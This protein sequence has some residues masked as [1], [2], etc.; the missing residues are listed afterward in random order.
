LTG[1]SHDQARG[2]EER[3]TR[4]KQELE[5][6]IK[7][8]EAEIA[9]KVGE[10]EKLT[11]QISQGEDL[12]KNEREKVTT[13]EGNHSTNVCVVHSNNIRLIQYYTLS[14]VYMYTVH[15]RIYT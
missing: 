15:T 8:L 7:A 12:L 13:I 10:S 5:L 1:G 14:V 11:Q 4:E 3:I 6:R 9:I 2:I